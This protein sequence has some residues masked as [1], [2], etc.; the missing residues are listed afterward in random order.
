MN[1][2]TCEPTATSSAATPCRRA[3]VARATST[4]RCHSCH[5]VRPCRHWSAT[6]VNASKA[7]RGGSP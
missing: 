4:E 1:A 6:A 2:E 3:N 5:G 7:G